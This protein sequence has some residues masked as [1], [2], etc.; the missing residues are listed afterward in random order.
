MVTS[1][2]SFK[3]DL[4]FAWLRLRLERVKTGGE[5]GYESLLDARLAEGSKRSYIGGTKVGKL[6]KPLLT[7]L[8]GLQRRKWNLDEMSRCCE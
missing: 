2:L 8:V 3:M 5:D 4:R 1:I 7:I 6:M